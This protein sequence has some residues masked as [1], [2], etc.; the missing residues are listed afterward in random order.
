MTA[1]TAFSFSSV[2]AASTRSSWQ[3]FRI[4]VLTVVVKGRILNCDPSR[5]TVGSCLLSVRVLNCSFGRSR[6]DRLF[7]PGAE[8]RSCTG[9]LFVKPGAEVRQF[10]GRLFVARPQSV[11]IIIDVTAFWVCSV[12]FALSC[13]WAT[14]RRVS[15]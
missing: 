2:A 15:V 3:M 9:K 1:N 12:A 13:R 4:L 14:V 5:G 6:A 8:V 10:A 7:K 11:M